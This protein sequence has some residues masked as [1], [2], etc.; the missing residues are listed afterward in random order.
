MSLS[1]LLST[2]SGAEEHGLANHVTG[3]EVSY[4][5]KVSSGKPELVN[6]EIAQDT[7]NIKLVEEVEKYISKKAKKFDKDISKHLVEECLN[8]DIDICFA[9]AQ[10]QIETNFGTTGIGRTRKSMFGVYVSYKTRNHST[11]AWIDLLKRRYLGN[12][13]SVYDLMNRYVTLSGK[14]YSQNPKYES[15]LRNAYN[16]IK[17]NTQIYKIQYNGGK[18]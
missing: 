4:V 17:K 11:T 6:K 9:L 2:P 15:T 5:E 13:K 16:S 18:S 12:K 7:L 3:T 1:I 8:N 14:R 10:T